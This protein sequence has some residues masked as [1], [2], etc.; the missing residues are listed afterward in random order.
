VASS[1]P[2]SL[3]SR[4]QWFGRI[5]LACRV[6]VISAIAGALLFSLVPQARD[7][8][9]DITYGALPSSLWAWLMWALF[10]FYMFFVWAFPVHFGARTMLNSNVWMVPQRVRALVQA[11]PSHECA[12]KFA[13]DLADVKKELEPLTDWIPRLLGVAPFLAVY[14]GLY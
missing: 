14:F 13:A 1:K 3:L 4:S 10:F 6:S 8:F 9:S 7:L 2:L 11:S 5:L 12:E